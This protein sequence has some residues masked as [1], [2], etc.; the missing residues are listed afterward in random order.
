MSINEEPK[1]KKKVVKLLIFHR[2]KEN[3]K[4]SRNRGV[5]K[6]EPLCLLFF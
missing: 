3:L 1:K 5:K 6:C 4:L 2:K